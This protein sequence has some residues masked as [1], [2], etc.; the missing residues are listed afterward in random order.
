MRTILVCGVAVSTLALPAM[1]ERPYDRN[2][3]KAAMEIVA[4]R[5]GEIRGG[6]SYAQVP[7][8]VA[9][10]DLPLPARQEM[11]APDVADGDDGLAPAV[12]RRDSRLVF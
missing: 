9:E 10:R 11:P 12:E 6:F 7:Q 1:A 2:L 5:M 4:S 8:L 3:E